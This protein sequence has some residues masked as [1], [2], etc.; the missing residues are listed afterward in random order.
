MAVVLKPPARFEAN[1]EKKRVKKKRN[2]INVEKCTQE[3]AYICNWI[4]IEK[5]IIRYLCS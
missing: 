1:E 2:D 3:F 4:E 5:L